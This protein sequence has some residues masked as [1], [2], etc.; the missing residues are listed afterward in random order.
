M[1]DNTDKNLHGL[2][3]IKS[4]DDMLDALKNMDYIVN[5][6]QGYRIG[7][8]DY[9]KKQFY[10]QYLIEFENNEEWI[11]QSTTSIRDRINIPQWHSAHIKRLN[12]YVKK[13]YVVVP[14]DMKKVEKEKA[15]SYN[16]D[17]VNKNIYSAIDGVIPFSSMYNLI[18]KNAAALMKSGV[19]H[20]KLGLHFEK[21]VAD[22]LNNKQ[23]FEKWKNNT[24][25]SVGYLYSLF[26]DITEKLG[27][28]SKDVISLNATTDIPKLPSGG[29]PKTDVMLQ[30]ETR[31]GSK[32]YTFS[33]K[34]S[35]REWVSVHEYTANAFCEVLNPQDDE[36]RQLLTDFQNAG[37][38]KA[39]GSDNEQRLS[40]IMK[41]KYALK[42]AKWVIG[43]LGGEG[44][45]T[46]QQADYI[47]TLNEDTDEYS[48]HSIDEYITE[49]QDRG[50]VG[51]LGTLF[52]WTYPSGGKG[53]RIQ[54]KGK[55]L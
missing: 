51:H 17:I 27:L 26:V 13:A 10:F 20:A 46:T 50:I 7:D 35:N 29:T 33:C 54:L 19:A 12:K 11:L 14:D 31:I 39:F 2:N 24:S 40:D 16:E 9:K 3:G 36:L 53:K 18:E 49:C 38:L 45:P 23:N 48:I 55:M 44:D 4:M 21:K 41:S 25:T 8:P 42:L 28:D 32:I 52:K 5:Y 43:G 37:G 6:E 34:R 30:V 15:D 22:A 1:K 47:I